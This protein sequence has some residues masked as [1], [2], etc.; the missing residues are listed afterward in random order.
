MQ[1]VAIELYFLNVASLHLTG[2]LLLLRMIP[3]PPAAARPVPSFALF[4]QTEFS[5]AA[6]AV[7][8][9]HALVQK[10]RPQLLRESAAMLPIRL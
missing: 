10:L 7:A 8:W 1:T 3:W 6:V 5:L 2:A 4:A 9:I